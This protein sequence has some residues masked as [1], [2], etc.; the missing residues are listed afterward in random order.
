MGGILLRVLVT[1]AT[2]VAGKVLPGPKP[3]E[4]GGGGTGAAPEAVDPGAGG[5]G[6]LRPATAGGPQIGAIS[7]AP[8][9]V[10]IQ[11][12]AD[13][14]VVMSPV[15]AATGLH[16][17]AVQNGGGGGG[18][19]AG[20]GRG[21]GP[22]RDAPPREKLQVKDEAPP[23]DTQGV[24]EVRK[25][26]PDIE[27]Q[28]GVGK[29]V[30]N[31]AHKWF[32][33]LSTFIKD[34]NIVSEEPP[35]GSQAEYRIQNPSYTPRSAPRI[36]RLYRAGR[37]V[38]EFKPKGLYEQ[39]LAKAKAYAMEMD[40]YEPLPDGARWQAKCITYDFDLVLDFMESNGYLSSEETTA[41]RA[42]YTPK[43]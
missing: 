32:E 27:Q 19:G 23:E 22:G 16:A 39:G 38:I 1:I 40:K 25:Y 13:G 31:F 34:P 36:D 7:Q 42:K 17:A 20:G 24:K 3:I 6:G 2:I 15:T 12:M 8:A 41:F 26:A 5:G 37:M 28:Q 35:A 21:S 4:G 33:K 30:G 29:Q 43:K 14:T 10:T 11:V 9:A 18:S